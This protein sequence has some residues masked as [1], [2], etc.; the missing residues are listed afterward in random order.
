MR[1]CLVENLMTPIENCIVVQLDD[2]IR[3]LK[4]GLRKNRQRTAIVISARKTVAGVITVKDLEF[5]QDDDSVSDYYKAP[6][7]TITADEPIGKARQRI[8]E[9]GNHQLIV[10]D[11]R[12]RPIGILWDYDATLGCD[13]NDE[14]DDVLKKN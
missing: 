11:D 10:V 6:A 13:D 2:T 8:N 4:K 1:L 7:W 5:A 14:S 9:N 3:T 12:K